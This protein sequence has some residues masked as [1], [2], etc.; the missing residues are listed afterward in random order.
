MARALRIEYPGASYHVLNRG[1][2]RR[3]I[4][5]G[6]RDYEHFLGI[7]RALYPRYRVV[8]LAYCLMPNHYHL[9]LQTP[10]GRLRRFMQELNGLYGQY[11]N[12]RTKRVGPLF[13]GRYK[14]VLVENETYG[15]SLVRYIHM[16]PVRAGLAE[17]PED[18]RWSSYAAYVGERKEDTF[19]STRMVLGQFSRDK[20]EAAR[21]LREFTLAEEAAPG[22]PAERFDGGTILGGQAFVREQQRDR[23]PRA[24]DASVASLRELRKPPTEVVRAME[25]RVAGMGVSPRLRRKLIVYGLHWGTSLTEKEIAE[26]AGWKSPMAVA[27]AIR[28][29]RLERGWNEEI[30]RLMT[31]L[32]A[33]VRG[34]RG[35]P[36]SGMSNVKL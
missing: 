29:L 14:A 3:T 36:I 33:S 26:L 1:V 11:F 35:G 12:R 13:Q 23:V 16:N 19:L 8:L 2:E 18:Y 34:G 5:G 15:K 32:E 4:F 24:A 10:L 7:I 21:R 6:P 27:Q 17:Q 30:G 20:A 22:S 9:F 31:V 25:E 28:R